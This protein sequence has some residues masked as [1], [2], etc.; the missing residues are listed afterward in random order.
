MQD[1]LWDSPFRLDDQLSESERLI[2][3]TAQGYSQ[4]RLLPRIVHAYRDERFH[5]EIMSEMGELGLLG[6]T[7]PEEYG[8]AGVGHVAYGLI[9]REIERVDSGYRSAMSVQSSLVMHPIHAYGSKAQRQKWLPRLAK[10][11]IV[12]CFGLPEPDAGSDPASMRTRAARVTG[13]YLLSGQKMWI[14]NSPIADI[15]VVWARSD[16]HEGKIKGFIVERGA[17]GFDTPKI[18]GKLSLRASVTGAIALD[19]VF[20]PEEN[21]LPAASGLSGP[22]GCLNKARFGIAWGVIGAAEYCWHAA[23]G[24]TLDRKQFARPL[25]ANQLIQF[26]LANMQTDI[27]LALQAALRVG[28]MMDEGSAAPEVVSLIK[29]NNCLKA[30]DVARVSRD[31]HGANGIADEFHVM[32]HMVNLET[33]N[34]YEGTQDVHALILGRSQTGIN[35]FVA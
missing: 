20:V 19:E 22:V 29:R 17:K 1:F 10:G 23:R 13:G 28:R 11:E 32:R 12:G 34:T 26:K 24:Y 16:A 9:A 31:I 6:P 18:E 5:R 21:L 7:I 14:T 8:G 3:D 30:L 4:G 25:A 2:R 15:A 27:A 33:V 35:A